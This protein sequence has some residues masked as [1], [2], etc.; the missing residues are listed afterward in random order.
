MECSKWSFIRMSSI[1]ILKR[2][3]QMKEISK[4]NKLNKLELSRFMIPSILPGN[5]PTMCSSPQNST[6]GRK[7]QFVDMLFE[8]ELS[9]NAPILALQRIS[10]QSLTQFLF[11]PWTQKTSPQIRVLQKKRNRKRKRTIG[12]TNLGMMGL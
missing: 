3:P 9:A 5:V 6:Q 4:K 2:M 7:A 10:K 11:S 1:T 12:R 8:W